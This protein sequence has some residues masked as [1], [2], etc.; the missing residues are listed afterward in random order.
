MEIPEFV[1][2]Q[3]INDYLTDS[4][5]NKT[6]FN[7]LTNPKYYWYKLFDP[8]VFLNLLYETFETI[9]SNK[10]NP[11]FIVDY[12]IDLRLET[13]QLYCLTT[14]LSILMI[15]KQRDD[16][17]LKN[18]RKKIRDVLWMPLEYD[19]LKKERLPFVIKKLP[20]PNISFPSSI[21]TIK[22][23]L[24]QFPAIEEKLAYLINCKHD[25]RHELLNTTKE[26]TFGKDSVLDYINIEIERYSELK[27]INQGNAGTQDEQED[28]DLSG[29]EIIFDKDII[30][31]LRKWFKKLIPDDRME[32]LYKLLDGQRITEKIPFNDRQNRLA[33]QFFYLRAGNYIDSSCRLV[34]ITKWLCN[35]FLFKK[36]S[37][38]KQLDNETVRRAV[39]NGEGIAK[40]E[41]N[42]I[43]TTFF[44]L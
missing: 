6:I 25:R 30:P 28:T 20:K 34:D 36:G 17:E 2:K 15:D 42:Y 32:D 9:R 27:L 26:N 18:C 8:L 11:D 19:Y 22:N 12:I 31:E 29:P 14:Y 24:F 35:S 40:K 39:S 3:S 16:H 23:T 38:H 5:F 7:R 44:E 43:E 10:T 41:S 21:E 1:P 13:K 37:K 33:G 4:T